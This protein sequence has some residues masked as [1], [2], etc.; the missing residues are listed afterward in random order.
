MKISSISAPLALIFVFI[1]LL[2]SQ[3]VWGLN[4]HDITC[5]I[6]GFRHAGRELVAPLLAVALYLTN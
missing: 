4:K 2:S 5:L 1:L 6:M 3:C